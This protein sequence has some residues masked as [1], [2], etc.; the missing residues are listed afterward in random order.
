M[1]DGANEIRILSVTYFRSWLSGNF[2][3]SLPCILAS[4]KTDD[5]PGRLFDALHEVLR[6]VQSSITNPLGKSRDG[7]FEP[8]STPRIRILI[9]GVIRV[10]GHPGKT[11]ELI[12]F[13]KFAYPSVLGMDA[14]LTSQTLWSDWEA[15]AS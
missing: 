10:I 6:I 12:D 8:I 11:F 5:R 9:K 13:P 3:Q 1:C 7:L 4:T 15:G 14:G 2:D